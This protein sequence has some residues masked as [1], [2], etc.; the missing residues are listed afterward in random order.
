MNYQL[1]IDPSGQF[2]KFSVEKLIDN[3][4]TDFDTFI[5]LKKHFILYSGNGYKWQREEL[6]SLLSQGHGE[7]YIRRQ[8]QRKVKMY[9]SVASLPK[10]EKEQAP[11]ERI[12]S[13][14]QVAA[15]FTECL[16]EG[17]I[18]E[19]CVKKAE[20]ISS[21][22]VN[23]IS[24]DSQC[25]KYLSGLADHDYY[26]YYHSV[27]V[28]TYAVAV[29]LSMGLTDQASLR[30]L[31]IGGL[32]HD[33]GKKNIPLEVLNKSGALTEN[34]WQLM[35]AHPTMGFEDM[36]THLLSH[37]PRE[38]IL[39]HHEKR[40]GS[41][42][43]DGLNHRSLLYEVQI[44]TLADIYDALTSSRSYQAKRTRYEALDFIKHKL[45]N[46][47]VCPEAFKALIECLA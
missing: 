3:S 46:E 9:E 7:L 24:E 4:T 39:H 6:T 12:N 23:C 21:E 42:Y 27:R 26:T 15:K 19:S 35:R 33:I 37:V 43:P 17:E 29:A 25:I 11:K 16:Y 36:P 31:A 47:E 44:A 1:A 41:G 34:E 40:N 18:T 45:L 32:F 13:I 2:E 30:D 5:Q 38:M 20:Q 14:Q 10:I 22:I 28:S 8:D